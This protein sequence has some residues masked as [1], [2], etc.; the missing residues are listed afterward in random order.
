[1]RET[2]WAV[3]L[4]M[5]LAAAALTAGWTV[6]VEA[7]PNAAGLQHP[8]HESIALM[9]FA[10]RADGR[11]RVIG[12]WLAAAFVFEA[13]IFTAIMVWYAQAL[14]DPTS[15]TT[16]FGFPPA[17]AWLLY[18]LWPSKLIFVVIFVVTFERA[19]WRPQDAARLKALLDKVER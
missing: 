12:P 1:M 19:Y 15:A 10:Y 4:L 8:L 17:T 7:P 11:L 6:L 13:V 18:A 9:A 3:A 2:T 14:E 16:L 5:L